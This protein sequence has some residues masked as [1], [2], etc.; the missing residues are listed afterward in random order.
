[1]SVAMRGW[2]IWLIMTI[3]IVVPVGAADSPNSDEEVDLLS[4]AA[5]LREQLA[6]LERELF[7]H[8]LGQLFAAAKMLVGGAAI[9]ACAL[10]DLD[11]RQPILS[12]LGEEPAG[13][14]QKGLARSL[15]VASQRAGGVAGSFRHLLGNSDEN[16][17]FLKSII[18]V[19]IIVATRA[20]MARG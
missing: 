13:S 14:S 20:E 12:A 7:G 19:G 6:K 10:G 3:L 4:E 11:N 18:Y 17:A 15:R 1:M 8:G 9:Q 2:N 5:R 16:V